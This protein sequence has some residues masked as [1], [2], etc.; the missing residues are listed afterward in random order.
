[1]SV[2][3]QAFGYLFHLF[4]PMVNKTFTLFSTPPP[5]ISLSLWKK[6]NAD[7]FLFKNRKYGNVVN[8]L[9]LLVN[10]SGVRYLQNFNY[11]N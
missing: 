5:L 7:I 8:V 11:N 2:I 6:K 10:Y 4:L 9:I 1:M 3:L